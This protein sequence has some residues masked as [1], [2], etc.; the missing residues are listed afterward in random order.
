MKRLFRF[1][2]V[3]AIPLFLIFSATGLRAEHD[4]ATPAQEILEESIRN[5]L[6]SHPE[7]II[8]VLDIL[9]AE[10]EVSEAEQAEQAVA[11]QQEAIFN[12][13]T[14]PVGGNPDGDVTI[15]E[16]FDYFCGYCK[17]VMPDLIQAMG[18]DPGIR[19]VYKEFPILGPDSVVVARIAL[20]AHRQ[21]PGKYPALHIAMM[22]SRARLNEANALGIARDY[23]FD[24]DRLKADMESPEIDKILAQNNALAE[25][26]GIRGTPGFVIGDQIIPG[27]I[28]IK[29]L[30]QLIAEAR[31]S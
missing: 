11:A 8:E 13:P 27:A 17:R 19:F 5:Y 20:A 9:R 29:T 28:D 14:S 12:D 25:K 21:S 10:R 1:A 15:V 24:V 31:Q 7:V 26:L 18:E 22:S 6:L 4:A 2:L 3:L 23:G 30:R 16:F